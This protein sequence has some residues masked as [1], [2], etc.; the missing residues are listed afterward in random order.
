MEP[1]GGGSRV[2][3]RHTASYSKTGTNTFS[4]PVVGNVKFAIAQGTTQGTNV[5]NVFCIDTEGGYYAHGD[6]LLQYQD[7][8][9]LGMSQSGDQL[10]IK[11]TSGNAFTVSI[12]YWSDEE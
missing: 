11:M 12:I 5:R 1:W 7:S 4:I 10:T 3:Y 8:T 6:T 9:A 2:L